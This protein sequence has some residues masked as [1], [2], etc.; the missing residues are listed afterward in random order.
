MQ[1]PGYLPGIGEGSGGDDVEC[2]AFP[3]ID[4]IIVA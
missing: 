1:R 2:D 4:N 3:W